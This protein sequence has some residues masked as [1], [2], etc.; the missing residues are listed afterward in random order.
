MVTKNFIHHLMG[1]WYL[2]KNGTPGY[3]ANI[4]DIT[5][6]EYIQKGW[7]A[8]NDMYYLIPGLI[9]GKNSSVF[10][11]LHAPD[12]SISDVGIGMFLGSGGGTSATKN[13]YNLNSPISYS[14]TGL[15]YIDF[16]CNAYPSSDVFAIYILTVKN[17]SSEDISISESG[18]FIQ[19]GQ[20]DKLLCLK[21]MIVHE[22]FDP[23]ILHP[24]ET[25]VFTINLEV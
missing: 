17:N 3:Q 20:C 19:T 14:N 24:G 21:F 10:T 15:H 25:R 11:E 18:M 6:K 5:G 13:D 23:V 8:S 1:Y 7:T 4:T 16:T 9:F 22:T 12:K 2:E